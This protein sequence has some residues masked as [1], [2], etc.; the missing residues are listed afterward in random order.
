MLR[1]VPASASMREYMGF[2]T[3]EE[4]FLKDWPFTESARELFR[5]IG[6]EAGDLSQEHGG[7]FWYPETRTVQVRG[8]QAEALIHEL[9]HAY[10]EDARARDS[11][12]EQLVTAVQRLAKDRD[13]RYQVA[14]TLAR[15]YVHGIKTQ[16]DAN[17]PTGYWQGMR[18]PDGSWMDWEMFAGLASGIMADLSLLPPYVRRFYEGLFEGPDRE[19]GRR[20]DRERGRLEAAACLRWR[21]R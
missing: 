14:A 12:A 2:E 11:I 20:G 9:A 19:I 15:H 8:S 3:M 18:Q 5:T 17:S 13:P 1:R 21:Q 7:G 16:P 6:F 4:P 10:W